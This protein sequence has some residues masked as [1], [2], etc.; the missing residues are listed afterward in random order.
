MK[1]YIV[2]SGSYSDYQIKRV[3]TDKAKAEEYSKWCYDS[4]GVDE[5]DTDEVFVPYYYVRAKC[6]INDD[7]SIK[8]EVDI[9]ETDQDDMGYEYTYCDDYHKWWVDCTMLFL[10][11]NCYAR[12]CSKESC[13]ERYI[14]VV[15][16][17]A[18]M[19]KALLVDGWSHDQIND[20]LKS[21][22]S[23]VE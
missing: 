5:W 22:M 10:A 20:M 2:T 1:I 6:R 12:D 8:T 4:N 23:E 7:G 13:K 21:K 16:D 18:A 14:K 3:F 11:R 19:V 17:M 15:L 9:K